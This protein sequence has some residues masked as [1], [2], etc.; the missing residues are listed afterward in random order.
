[1]KYLNLLALLGVLVS[2]TMA[3]MDLRADIHSSM[4]AAKIKAA[5]P[6]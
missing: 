3:A 1:M 2:S 6:E 5:K 4:A